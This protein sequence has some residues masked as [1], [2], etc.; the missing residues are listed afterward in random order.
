MAIKKKF[1]CYECNWKFTRN[2]T[3]SL[4]PYCGRA[5]VEEDIAQDANDIVNEVGRLR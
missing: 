2:Y 1:R 5:A 3:P 4:C